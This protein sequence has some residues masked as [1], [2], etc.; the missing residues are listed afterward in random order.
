MTSRTKMA[1]S[2]SAADGGRMGAKGLFI[3]PAGG[4]S[5]FSSAPPLLSSP[6]FRPVPVVWDRERVTSRGCIHQTGSYGHAL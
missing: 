6:S 1:P 5:S 4:Y 2:E 3:Q